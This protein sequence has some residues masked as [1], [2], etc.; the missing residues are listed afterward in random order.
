M[1][2]ESSRLLYEGHQYYALAAFVVW[3]QRFRWKAET[4]E[5]LELQPEHPRPAEL[6]LNISEHV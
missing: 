1:A 3:S 6:S 2:L 5:R 4:E